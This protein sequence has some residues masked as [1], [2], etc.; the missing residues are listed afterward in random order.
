MI[1]KDSPEIPEKEEETVIKEKKE[2]TPKKIKGDYTVEEMEEK[3]S[4]LFNGSAFLLRAEITYEEKEFT[5]EAKDIIRLSK[6]YP[7]VNTILTFLDPLFLILGLFS[8]IKR[9]LEKL[10]KRKKKGGT[11]GDVNADYNPAEVGRTHNIL[12]YDRQRQDS[13]S[14]GDASTI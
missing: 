7:V 3:L 4:R 6:K 10:P 2:K 5:Q 13:F 1:K 11:D 14:A 8:K 12:R 9:L